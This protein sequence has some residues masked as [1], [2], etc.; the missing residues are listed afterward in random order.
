MCMQVC[1]HLIAH[2]HYEASSCLNYTNILSFSLT[3]G[4]GGGHV[5]GVG[6]LEAKQ[7][8]ISVGFDRIVSLCYLNSYTLALNSG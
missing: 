1:V 4:G 7:A 8:V 5:V 2:T 6:I 3:S